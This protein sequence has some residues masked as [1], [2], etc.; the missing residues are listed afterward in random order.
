MQ[1]FYDYSNLPP[2]LTG[3]SINT[4]GS[5]TPAQFQA[6][7]PETVGMFNNFDWLSNRYP[8]LKD[9]ISTA[10]GAGFSDEEISTSLQNIE[11]KLDFFGKNEEV[12]KVLGRTEQTINNDANFMHVK[13]FDALRTVFP[14]KTDDDIY[15][16]I[17]LSRLEGVNPTAFL[18]SDTLFNAFLRGQNARESLLESGIRGGSNYLTGNTNGEFGVQFILG[19]ISREDLFKTVQKNSQNFIPEARILTPGNRLFAG[20]SGILTQGWK[21][22]VKGVG[23]GGL[24]MGLAGPQTATVAGAIPAM[25]AGYYAAVAAELFE[26]QAGNDVYELLQLKDEN[27]QPLDENVARI[28]ACITGGITVATEFAALKYMLNVIPGGQHLKQLIGLDRQHVINA[29]Q[30][31]PILRDTLRNIAVDMSKGI[32]FS[33]L[34]NIIEAINSDAKVPIAQAISQQPFPKFDWRKFAGDTWEHVKDTAVSSLRDFTGSAL[35]SF[36]FDPRQA[37]IWSVAKWAKEHKLAVH[38]ASQLLGVPEADIERAMAENLRA[39]QLEAIERRNNP[40]ADTSAEINTNAD[41]ITPNTAPDTNLDTSAETVTHENDTTQNQPQYVYIPAEDFSNF[42]KDNPDVDI[43]EAF[44]AGD[45]VAFTPEV[46]AQLEENHQDFINSIAD[47]IRRGAQSV[48]NNEAAMKIIETDPEKADAFHSEENQ[49]IYD[50]LVSQAENAGLSA[51]EADII[52]NIVR[53][54]NAVSIATDGVP[55]IPVSIVTPENNLDFSRINPDY[56]INNPDTWPN[57]NRAK[58]YSELSAQAKLPDIIQSTKDILDIISGKK[59][60]L[61]EDLTAKSDELFEGLKSE[62]P[63]NIKSTMRE[64]LREELNDYRFQLQASGLDVLDSLSALQLDPERY[65]LNQEF[66]QG[67]RR[68]PDFSYSFETQGHKAKIDFATDGINLKARFKVSGRNEPLIISIKNFRTASLPQIISD[69]TSGQSLAGVNL[70]DTP[71]VQNISDAFYR[72]W[73]DLGLNTVPAK[74][75]DLTV[76]NA[77]AVRENI[78]RPEVKVDRD[79]PLEILTSP[80]DPSKMP[81]PARTR[82]LRDETAWSNTVEELLTNPSIKTTSRQHY[83]VMQTPLVL[84]LVGAQH[85]PIKINSGKLQMILRDHSSMTPDLLKQIPR[86]ITDPITIFPSATVEPGGMVILTDLKDSNGASVLAAVHLDQK[87]NINKLA[88]TYPKTTKKGVPRNQWFRD[89]IA[90]ALTNGSP[91][92]MNTE[93]AAQWEAE[94]GVQ[95]MQQGDI[96]THTEQDLIR[97]WNL[98]QQ[99]GYYKLDAQGLPLS[100]YFERGGKGFIRYFNSA[101]NSAVQK[102]TRFWATIHEIG[103]NMFSTLLMRAKSGSVQSL[104]DRNTLITHAGFTVEQFEADRKSKGG[105]REKVAEYTSEA[106]TKYVQEGKAPTEALQKVFDRARN[107]FLDTYQDISA[108]FGRVTIDDDVRAVFDR[109]LTIPRHPKS[110]VADFALDDMRISRQIKAYEDLRQQAERELGERE[111]A[112]TELENNP[113]AFQLNPDAVALVEDYTNQ[114]DFREIQ[115]DE[116]KAQQDLTKEIIAAIKSTGLGVSKAD[117]ITYFGKEN[118]DT[119]Y[120]LWRGR[121]VYSASDTP[122][123]DRLADALATMGY[124]QMENGEAFGTGHGDTQALMNWLFSFDPSLFKDSVPSVPPNIPVNLDTVNAFLAS[125]GVDG[126]TDYLHDRLNH[127]ESILKSEQDLPSQEIEALSKEKDEINDWLKR[128][129]PQ[130]DDGIKPP[131]RSKTKISQA[132]LRQGIMTGYTLGRQEEKEFARLHEKHAL[133][134]QRDRLSERAQARLDDLKAKREADKARHLERLQTIR[135]REILKRDSLVQRKNAELRRKI[136]MFTQRINN[137]KNA[138]ARSNERRD[139]KKMVNSILRMSRASSISWNK[140]QEIKSLLDEYNLSR[141]GVQRRD[142]VRA[143]IDFPNNEGEQYNQ[144]FADEFAEL[145]NITQQEVDDFISQTHIEDMNLLQVQELFSKVKELFRQGREEF[146][147]WKND[148]IDRRDNLRSTLLEDLTAFPEG[149]VRVIKGKEDMRKNFLFGKLGEAVTSYWEAAKTPGR[150]LH[151]LG[152]NFRRVLEDGFTSRRGEAYRWIHLR[153]TGFFDTLEQNGISLRHLLNNAVTV[154]GHTFTWEEALSI[155]L[156]WQNKKHQQA[157]LYGNFIANKADPLKPYQNEAQALA[158]IGKIIQTVENNPQYKAIADWILY[159]FDTHFDRINLANINNFNRGMNKE[160]NYSPMM[161]LQHQTNQGAIDSELEN[162]GIEGNNGQIMMK[163]ADNFTQSRANIN[164]DNQQPVN[165]HLV[166]VWFNS[167][168]AQEYNAA[169]GGYAA[170]VASALLMRGDS[171]SVQ[172]IIKQK[173]G[174]P[175]WNILR[176]I[177]NNSINDHLQREIDTASMLASFLVKARSAAYVPF[178]PA[179]MLAQFFSYFS[180]IP[181]TNRGHLIRSLWAA[182]QD[183]GRFLQRVAQ[184]GF[185]EAW[186]QEGEFFHGVYEKS[187]E[188]RYT[189]GDPIDREVAINLERKPLQSNNKIINAVLQNNRVN[190][191]VNLIRKGLAFGYKGVQLIDNWTKSIV[192]DAVYNS[193][194][195]NGKSHEDAVRLAN[196]AVAETQPASNN[197]QKAAFLRG[198]SLHQ[199][200]FS[201]FMNALVPLYNMAVVDT[202]YNLTNNKWNGVKNTAFTLLAVGMSFAAAGF[203]KDSL[204]G[205]LWSGNEQ[206]DGS[207]DDFWSWLADTELDSLINTIPIFNRFIDV[208]FALKE[209]KRYRPYDRLTEP[210]ERIARGIQIYGKDN[211]ERNGEAWENIIHGASLLGLPIPFSGIRQWLRLFGLYDNER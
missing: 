167:M 166:N 28:T 156:G 81:V 149:E 58:E 201:Q 31:N 121:G 196:R 192:F 74:H 162:A 118:L 77:K 208:I 191:S 202:A 102:A 163:V 177:Y 160:E 27:G 85:L 189:A 176:D 64:I 29:V 206:P 188:L 198:G 98:H 35:L 132:D 107:F 173:L 90:D 109:L 59:P 44:R 19:Q 26:D 51:E 22:T 1:D 111:Q 47:D 123:A 61:G 21:N 60:D 129:D 75:E 104:E 68:N 103:H 63:S 76:D 193:E 168:Y 207:V 113:E 209:N 174:S 41:E 24:L 4:N 161:R 180:A 79:V 32:G 16:A 183:G 151:S 165:L 186:K 49:K 210:F 164:K 203:I 114:R 54:V 66:P 134:S 15:N 101:M 205:R 95:L 39:K 178:N 72:V 88:S 89:Q 105:V 179:T 71:L 124:F 170:D 131:K 37:N 34:N 133:D 125:I 87:G 145:H 181:Y 153:E 67:K 127:I 57:Q 171:G 128:L 99:E 197:A 86:A 110:T 11:R 137:I 148:R 69:I 184:L 9:R 122:M 42:I 84:T 62:T 48:T 96:Y 112:R 2:F 10:R 83:D 50:V 116:L 52:G 159:D 187:P 138:I 12:N 154:D 65:A 7:N 33:T 78:S 175:V 130:F 53:T 56:D 117:V 119:F 158:A 106:W 200:V 97:L 23:L 93:K 185:K 5:P 8:A 136:N 14:N 140:L 82:L 195:E 152:E 211:G 172:Q 108:Q 126:T 40:N 190:S 36:L 70:A 18:Q 204:N 30:S 150:F 91:I 38:N 13:Q 143:L 45:E 20:V 142:L 139:I 46:F 141:N 73:Q 169:L 80:T 55:M 100:E 199:L 155:Y 146:I 194:L 147:A 25:A 3:N 43:S 17:E 182:I 135:Q 6:T 120:K 144:D 94:T 92:Y 115:M 157:I